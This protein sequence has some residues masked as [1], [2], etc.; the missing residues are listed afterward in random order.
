MSSIDLNTIL[1]RSERILA[2]PLENALVMMDIEGGD[3]Y[4]L[5]DIG[6]A[7]WERLAEP[8]SVQS[9]CVQLIAA[10]AVE[11]EVCQADVLAFLNELQEAGAL[12]RLDR[13]DA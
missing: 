12:L 9:L 10:Y 3:Y 11:P 1:V 5:D 7:I 8:L 6:A 4:S 13:E 2:S